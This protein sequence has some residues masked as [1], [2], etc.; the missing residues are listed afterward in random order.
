VL[1]GD[2]L[3][4]VIALALLLF[5]A[6]LCGGRLLVA[7]LLVGRCVIMNTQYDTSVRPWQEVGEADDDDMME[8]LPEAQP[9]VWTVR[10]RIVVTRV[11]TMHRANGGLRTLLGLHERS[12]QGADISGAEL[13]VVGMTTTSSTLLRTVLPGARAVAHIDVAPRMPE[14][15]YLP[16]SSSP[17]MQ[18][19]VIH[20]SHSN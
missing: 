11:M 5:F 15:S 1:T 12:A 10:T 18:E 3:K 6:P 4:L 19:L 8:V 17:S 14:V 9:P 13:L 20:E 2:K 7:C 16:P